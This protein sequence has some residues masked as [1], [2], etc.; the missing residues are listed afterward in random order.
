MRLQPV[1]AQ[2]LR[3]VT[4]RDVRLSGGQLIPAGVYVELAQYSVMRSEAWG[5][6]DGDA[7]KPV[8]SCYCS[9]HLKPR[10]LEKL[11][12]GGG[13]SEAHYL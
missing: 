1:A 6:A 5:W 11:N 12:Q 9:A 4:T 7:F 8:S 10:T 3:R 13:W 2:P